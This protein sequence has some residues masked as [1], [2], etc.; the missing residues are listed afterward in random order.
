MSFEIDV[1]NIKCGGCAGSIV[2]GLKALD[3]VATV[4]VD[5]EHGRVMVAAEDALRPQVSEK[6]KQLGYPEVGTTA[7]LAAAKARAK[8]FVSCAVGR[9]GDAS[10]E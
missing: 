5:V 6:L 7:G 3:G 8:S 9:F 2:S 10:S 1:E 4:N